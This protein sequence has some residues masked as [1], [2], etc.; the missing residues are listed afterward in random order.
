MFGTRGLFA[1]NGRSPFA[2]F[3]GHA[4]CHRQ[5]LEKC[6]S[7]VICLGGRRKTTVIHVVLWARADDGCGGSRFVPFLPVFLWDGRKR[8]V[9]TAVVYRGFV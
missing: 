3:K 7:A 4:R 6:R 1:R 8:G 2:F 9:K 5:R